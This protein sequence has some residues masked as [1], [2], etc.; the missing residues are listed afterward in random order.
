MRSERMVVD[1]V[2]DAN[3]ASL[4]VMLTIERLGGG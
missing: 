1:E 3:R 4:E 2:V